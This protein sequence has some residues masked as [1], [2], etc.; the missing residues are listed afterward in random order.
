M[1]LQHFLL[2]IGMDDNLCV[3]VHVTISDNR[4][5]IQACLYVNVLLHDMKSTYFL[6]SLVLDF[7]MCPSHSIHS[8]FRDGEAWKNQRFALAKLITPA[9]F[10]GYTPGFNRATSHL[11]TNLLA[12]RNDQDYVKDAV[13]HLTH[14]GAECKKQFVSY[15]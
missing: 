4:G 12:S 2:N 1:P 7:I 14:W 6:W 3:H 10:Y 13:P 9:N 15:F 5:D 11:M 8:F